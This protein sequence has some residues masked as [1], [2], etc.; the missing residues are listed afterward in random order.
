MFLPG[1]S[2]EYSNPWA[3]G[4]SRDAARPWTTELEVK[5]CPNLEP[6]A[7]AHLSDVGR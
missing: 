2:V 1:E 3:P 7:I 5:P 6:L 4:Q